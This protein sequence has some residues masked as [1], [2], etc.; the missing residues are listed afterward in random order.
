MEG[1]G[2]GSALAVGGAA[3]E[4]D[5]SSGGRGDGGVALVADGALPEGEEE[6]L[7]HATRSAHATSE[8]GPST[9]EGT[10]GSYPRVARTSSLRG[11]F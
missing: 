7:P 10:S 11:R 5:G 1:A 6:E 3:G 2:A 4:A 9:R 8:A